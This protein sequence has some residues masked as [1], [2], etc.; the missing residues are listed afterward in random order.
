MTA[1][2]ADKNLTFRD[3]QDTAVK[4]DQ[5]PSSD[6]STDKALMVPLLGLAGEAG[7]LLTEFKKWL[8]QGDIY[9]PFCP[10]S[11]ETGISRRLG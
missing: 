4:T 1:D 10:A 11:G 7:S 8:R 5:V 2:S 9:R 3:Y 6:G